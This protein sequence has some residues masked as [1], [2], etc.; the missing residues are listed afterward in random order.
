MVFRMGWTCRVG[1]DGGN[2]VEDCALKRFVAMIEELL[3]LREAGNLTV[4][5]LELLS[6]SVNITVILE[7]VG[8]IPTS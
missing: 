8:G 3:W 6:K 7:A 1:E 5:E 4:E 2:L